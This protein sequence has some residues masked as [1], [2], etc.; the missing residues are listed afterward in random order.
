MMKIALRVMAENPASK[1]ASMRK[2]RNIQ[3]PRLEIRAE[4]G[5]ENIASL[6]DVYRNETARKV[7]NPGRARALGPDG[8]NTGKVTSHSL[9]T[10]QPTPARRQ[11]VATSI[12]GEKGGGKGKRATG[13]TPLP[14]SGGQHAHGIVGETEDEQEGRE[15]T[16]RQIR[17]QAQRK[18]VD[19]EGGAQTQGQIAQGQIK[20]GAREESEGWA[21]SRRA[22][23]FRPPRRLASQARR[24]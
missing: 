9:E 6:H 23:G 20:V 15:E 19:E 4:S 3:N 17:W 21:D 1:N 10:P 5:F 13:R 11:E 7:R 16:R 24:D 2:G 18:E 8:T 14:Q 22:S 12:A